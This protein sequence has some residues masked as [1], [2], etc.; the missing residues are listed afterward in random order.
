[1]DEV[2]VDL[3][4][5]RTAAWRVPGADPPIVCLHGA[6]VSS[7]ENLPMLR[8]FAG[9]RQAWSVDLP[10]FGASTSRAG[11]LGTAELGESLVCWLEAT[12]LARSLLVGCS[13]GCQLATLVASRVPER[14]AGLVLVGPTTDPAARSWPTQLGRWLR[15]SVHEP[16]RLDALVLRDYRDAGARRVVKTFVECLDDRVEDRLPHVAAPTLV[17]R[18]ERDAMVPRPW[19]EEVTRLLPR[20]RLVT[21]AGLGHM[22]PFADPAGFAALVGRFVTEEVS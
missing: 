19:A 22:V 18:G 13:F 1:M 7:R 14:V 3:P 9:T 4:Q 10:G 21:R 17:V 12:G 2:V 6:G 8:E 20:A 5:G 15:N 16:R 11:V